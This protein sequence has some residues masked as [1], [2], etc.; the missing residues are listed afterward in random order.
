LWPL[1]A[2]TA[3]VPSSNPKSF[4][5]D[6]PLKRPRR[7]KSFFAAAFFCWPPAK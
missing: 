6:D 2:L 7:R 4:S 5:L 1:A 3:K